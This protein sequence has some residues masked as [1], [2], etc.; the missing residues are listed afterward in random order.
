M[1]LGIAFGIAALFLLLP[2]SYIAF[3]V[4]SD[5]A[6]WCKALVFLPTVLYLLV[7]LLIFMRG[8]PSQ[9]MMNL[10]L[11]LTLCVFF[12]TVVFTIISLLG[13]LVGLFWGPAPI[14][15]NRIGLGLSIL[16]LLMAIFGIL[17][18]WRHVTVERVTL[19]F[20]SLPQ[21]FNGYKIVQLSDLHIGTYQSSPSTVA[22]IV[23]KVNAL[24]PDLIVF[25]GDIV[26]TNPD[27]IIPFVDV[28]KKLKAKDGVL[29]VLGNHDYCLYRKY[30]A[31]DSPQKATQRVVDLEKEM[32]WGVLLNESV[33]IVHDGDS[34]AVAGVENKG[35]KHF[36]D[37]G[38]LKK[39]MA[40]LKADEF[41]ILLSH[42]PSH[43]R[44]EVIPES[45]IELTLSGHTHAMQFKIGNFSPAM[46][47]YKE[48]GGVYREGNQTLVVS[49]G[50]GG[51]VAFRFGVYP[52]ILEITLSTSRD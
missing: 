15:F 9:I 42:D 4:L 27:E 17:V 45:D 21:A 37:R 11:W 30:I 6:W 19:D 1:N 2:D 48:W 10:V 36:T 32:G 40:G 39:A 18:G 24:N 52:Q 7:V 23:K 14:L 16:W 44:S 41:K 5:S 22:D 50:T 35:G 25:T 33:Q 51:N 49:T 20:P 13:K 8:N 26:N 31:P 38:D 3:G 34:I 12:P 46:W 29:S 28:L 43:W 47:T